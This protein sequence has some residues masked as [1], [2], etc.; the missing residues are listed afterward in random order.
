MSFLGTF[1]GQII[2][3]V[4]FLIFL[5]QCTMY[6]GIDFECTNVIERY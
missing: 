5:V 3:Y 2:E 4:F 6:I 1:L